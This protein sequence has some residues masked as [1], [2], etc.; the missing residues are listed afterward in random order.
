M[1]LI[2][3]RVSIMYVSVIIIIINNLFIINISPLLLF[4]LRGRSRLRQMFIDV[5]ELVRAPGTNSI[6]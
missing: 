2:A 1:K 5:R 6:L 3:S 4:P